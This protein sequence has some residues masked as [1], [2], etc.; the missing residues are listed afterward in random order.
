ML[1]DVDWLQAAEEAGHPREFGR[2][3]NRKLQR[4]GN[5]YIQGHGGLEL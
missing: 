5:A 1:G 2:R 3:V 4:Q